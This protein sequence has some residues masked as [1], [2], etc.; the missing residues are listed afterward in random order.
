MNY[1]RVWLKKSSVQRKRQVSKKG[2]KLI[3][4]NMTYDNK[5]FQNNCKRN[6]HCILLAEGLLLNYLGEWLKRVQCKEKDKSVLVKR[7][8][9]DQTKYDLGLQRLLK[10]LQGI[11]EIQCNL[12]A[13]GLLLNYP[14]WWLKRS[15]MQRKR[16][17]SIG[18]KG[19]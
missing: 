1:P 10:Q 8:Q 15:S 5:G 12:R 2:N 19:N 16:Q 7:E 11:G 6:L 14:R 17:V 9:V 3:K 13:G 4:P 18:R